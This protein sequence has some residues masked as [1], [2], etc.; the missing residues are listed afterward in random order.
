MHEL[1]ITR[2]IVAV[3]AEAAQGRRVLKVNLDLGRLSGVLA[4]A[5]AFCFDEVSKGTPLEGARL[6]IRELEGRGRCRKCQAELAT[7]TLFTA[8]PCG[9]RDL[10][11]LSGEELQIKSMELEEAA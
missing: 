1:G 3:V 8:C 2:N 10:E 9:G 7:P 6:V 4:Q 5:V 11:R